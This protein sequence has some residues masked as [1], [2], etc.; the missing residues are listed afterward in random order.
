MIFRYSIELQI[1]ITDS[2]L[3]LTDNYNPCGVATSKVPCA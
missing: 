2:L 1:T 3:M